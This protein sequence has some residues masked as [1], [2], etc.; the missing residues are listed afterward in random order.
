MILPLLTLSDPENTSE[1]SLDPL[2]FYS[3][4][5]HLAT[6]LV[7]GLR[8]RM[9]HPRFLTAMAAGAAVC[10]GF[11]EETV[12]VDGVSPPWQ[13]YEWYVVQAL[14]R[15]FDKD[16]PHEIRGLPGSEKAR[17]AMRDNVPLSAPRYLKTASVFGFHGVYR[18]LAEDIE[19]T[20][21][22]MVGEFGD[23]LL[24]IWEQ[25]QSLPGFYTD[26]AGKGRDLCSRL[27]DAVTDGLKK[28]A[29]AR[30]WSWGVNTEIADVMAP[31]RGGRKETQA[32]YEALTSHGSPNRAA[33]IRFITSD[34]GE[35]ILKTTFSE[36]T[37]HEELKTVAPVEVA[38]LLGAIDRYERF[39][40]LLQ[41]AFDGA[42]SQ[43]S[44]T[45]QASVKGL[46]GV[47]EVKLAAAKIGDA[48][49]M[50]AEHLASFGESLSFETDFG[51][52]AGKLSAPDFVTALLN[53]HKTIQ[54]K[55]PPAGKRPWFEQTDR[56]DCLIHPPYRRTEGGRMDDRYVHAYRSWPLLSF[57]TDLGR[58]KYE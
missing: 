32:I 26:N 18:T 23:R 39:A 4:S 48:F 24:R 28:G 33:V 22:D 37:F 13:V 40:R 15:T 47:P 10:R 52:F 11:D 21:E 34:R 42:L 1:G 30:G 8:E 35:T 36:R 12:A 49:S 54:K 5:N 53:H 27:K 46:A 50:A 58:T 56:G 55:K 38:V 29:V 7:P 3:I 51:A 57:M 2:G 20:I 6:K 16:A 14:V 19:L 43:M 44:Q 41:D 31:Y 17:K 45:S 25:E 9:S